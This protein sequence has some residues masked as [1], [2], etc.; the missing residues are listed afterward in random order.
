M[1]K[2]VQ[3]LIHK[4]KGVGKHIKNTKML[5]EWRFKINNI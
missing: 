2:V 5:Y 1:T 4:K 3:A